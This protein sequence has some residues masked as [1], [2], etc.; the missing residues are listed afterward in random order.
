MCAE[1]ALAAFLTCVPAGAAAS[2]FTRPVV[3]YRLANGLT[4][5]LAPDPA[6]EEASVVVH[7]D[8]GSADDPPG[9][10]GLAHLVEHL[11]FDGSRHVRPGEYARWTARVGAI[12]VTGRTVPDATNYFATVPE[13]GL[14]VVFWLESDRMGL[15]LDR[16]D[17]T[18]LDTEKSIIADESRDR[19]FDQYLGLLGP[20]GWIQLFPP[21]HP[22]HRDAL[23]SMV[24]RCTMDDVR[25]FW[26]TWYSPSNATV[27]VAGHFDLGA[28][29]SLID[30]YFGDL[31]SDSPPARPVLPAAWRVHDT[32]IEAAANVPHDIV[33][34][35]WKTPPLDQPGDPE[36]D[37]A[38]AILADPAGRLQSQLVSRGLAISV[39]AR[40]S[41]Y[42]RGSVFWISA[43]VADGSSADDV[44]AEI[45]RT[46]RE[47]SVRVHLDEY[48]RAREEWFDSLMLGLETSQGRASR[49][50]R[51]RARGPW[52]LEKYDETGPTEIAT[53]V[54][55]NLTDE[56][57]LVVI[58]RRDPHAPGQGV[59]RSRKQRLP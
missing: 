30:R 40:E 59:V 41:S 17:Q 32:L 16:L 49:I 5:V 13:G 53:S 37:L 52:E 57:R 6:L 35:R 3:R 47:L 33:T 12:G 10:D 22:Y 18:A 27:A 2:D 28:V 8:V 29:R 43:V 44:V 11:M 21:W 26:R 58:V 39:S 7:Y 46:V 34:F 23:S 42:L 51:E 24:S 45:D 20:A 38:A 4:V 54:R 14:P 25:A 1:A 50:V 48:K 36:L 15:F 55:L 31:P 19:I 9:K 56:N